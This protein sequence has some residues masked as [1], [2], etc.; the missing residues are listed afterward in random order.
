MKKGLI[1]DAKLIAARDPAAKSALEVV[2]LY[3]GFHVLIYH[4]LSHWFYKMGSF[5][6]A[7]LIS[8]IGRF[9]TGI[10]IHPGATLGSGL[11]ID[12]GMGIVI[13]ESAVIGDNCT[14][15]HGVTLGGTGKEKGKKR[16][17]TIGNNVLIGAGAKV[18]GPC[19]I[20]DN[21]RIGANTFVSFDVEPYSTVVGAKG[22]IVRKRNKKPGSPS[23]ALDQIHMPDPIAQE[24]CRLTSRIE[25]LENQVIGKSNGPC[26][27]KKSNGSYVF[28]NRGENTESGE[29]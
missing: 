14:I 28:E 1:N 18:L 26:A 20:G 21:S 15:Y 3:P 27:I 2:L 11:F 25:H 22:R 17:P 8:Q 9:F 7:R 16:H 10:E 23:E 6:I 13:G 29:E 19:K 24:L 5:F 12:H 4:K